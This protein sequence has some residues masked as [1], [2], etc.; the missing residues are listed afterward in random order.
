VEFQS[1]EHEQSYRLA[2]KALAHARVSD[3]ETARDMSS[4]DLLA[5]VADYALAGNRT[6]DSGTRVQLRMLRSLARK[7]TAQSRTR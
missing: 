5:G 2:C 7:R 1:P 4:D 6:D 3:Y